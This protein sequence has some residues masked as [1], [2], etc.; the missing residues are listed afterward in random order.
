MSVSFTRSGGL[1]LRKEFLWFFSASFTPDCF[2]HLS[3]LRSLPGNGFFPCFTSGKEPAQGAWLIPASPGV[4]ACDFGHSLVMGLV[5]VLGLG[6]S[7]S[8]LSAAFL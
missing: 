3:C 1:W 5:N 4:R 6:P 7:L 8:A 2:A